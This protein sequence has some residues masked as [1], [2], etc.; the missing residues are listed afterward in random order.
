VHRGIE[1]MSTGQTIFFDETRGFGFIRP[2]GGGG[3]IFVHV[4]DITNRD[5][6][7]QGERVSFEAIMDDRRGKPRAEKVRVL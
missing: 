6:L 2:D 4:R 7:T 1:P 5:K 3:D